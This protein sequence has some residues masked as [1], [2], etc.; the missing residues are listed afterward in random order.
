MGEALERIKEYI[1]ELFPNLTSDRYFKITSRN[2]P[3][4]NCIAWAYGISNRWMWP[5]TGYTRY[6]DGVDYW[7]SEEIMSCDV[8]N[9]IAAFELK[10]YKL[11]NDASFEEGYRKI[12]LY[13]NPGTTEC[14]HAARQLTNGAWTSKLGA[15]NDIQHG[16]P[17]SI[18][19]VN[20][21]VVYCYMKREF[22]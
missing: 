22:F 13:V 7:P 4:Y 20:Y 1:I 2:T 9:F 16:T 12:V 14:T 6:L 19:G 5:N 18:E 3:V 21:G 17:Q 8:K 10:G 15:G 11:C